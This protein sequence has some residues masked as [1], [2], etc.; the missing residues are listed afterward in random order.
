M[1]EVFPIEALDV[2]GYATRLSAAMLPTVVTPVFAARD[3]PDVVV[4]PPFI[5]YQG[6][7]REASVSNRCEFD[8]LAA[9]GELTV[10]DE[11]FAAQDGHELWV[12]QA[13]IA[14]YGPVGD[15]DATL[16]E[17]AREHIQAAES[18]LTAGNLQEALRLAGIAGC[19]DGRRYQP[20][21]IKA[22]IRL[23]EGNAAAVKVMSRLAEGLCSP[24]HFA[25]AVRSY[26][27]RFRPTR[28]PLKGVAR[29]FPRDLSPWK[30]QI[31]A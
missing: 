8:G 9:R 28:H 27:D 23:T 24:Q 1:P 26:V 2:I 18:A 29:R 31:A 20:L 11:P 14:R 17:I 25:D 4:F 30:R 7:V 19:A 16:S 15:V 5:I 21:A 3:T 10:I 22:A 13:H 12:D 6:R